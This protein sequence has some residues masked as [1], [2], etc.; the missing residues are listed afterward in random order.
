MWKTLI[1]L[2]VLGYAGWLGYQKYLAPV[3]SP[4]FQE[5]IRFNEL[6]TQ[7]KT[8]E[9]ENMTLD[10]REAR[11]LVS[12]S[13]KALLDLMPI[14]HA[15]TWNNVVETPSADGKQVDFTAEEI[16]AY[17][18]GGTTS[19]FGSMNMRLKWEGSLVKSGDYWKVTVFA[20]TVLGS[21]KKE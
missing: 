19:T 18:P 12:P 21:S 13:V 4:A 2:G 14:M 9:A 5:F 6:M 15:A 17:D 10:G 16:I 20:Y 1:V 7:G 8:V 3:G 11:G